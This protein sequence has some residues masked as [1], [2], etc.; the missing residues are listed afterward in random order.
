MKDLE[1]LLTNVIEDSQAFR[2]ACQAQIISGLH[3]NNTNKSVR[4]IQAC[5]E[6]AETMGL[7]NLYIANRSPVSKFAIN[8][9]RK[10]AQQVDQECKPLKKSLNTANYACLSSKKLIKSLNQLDKTLSA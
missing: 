6:A 7:L 2:Q 5:Y 4:S 3:S 1:K 10:S 9:A 8:L